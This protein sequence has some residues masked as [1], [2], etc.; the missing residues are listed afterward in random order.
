MTIAKNLESLSAA[1]AML[2]AEKVAVETDQNWEL[3][4]TTYTFADESRLQI[5]G[6]FV[7]SL[8]VD[9]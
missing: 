1:D 8:R 3:E 5:S 7:K 2:E 6:A 9:E 4:A